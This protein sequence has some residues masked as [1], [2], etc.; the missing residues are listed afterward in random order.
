MNIKDQDEEAELSLLGNN[1]LNQK[2]FDEAIKVFD[3]RV[4]KYPKSAQAHI[5][6]G[7]GHYQN[8][9]AKQAIKSYRTAL[10]LEPRYFEV[11][12]FLGNILMAEGDKL[13]GLE[14][15]KKFFY[16]DPFQADIR[17]MNDAMKAGNFNEAQQFSAHV[18]NRHGSH[19]HALE[20]MAELS[21]RA[22]FH[23]E[24]EK[25]LRHGLVYSPYN[26]IL[27]FK[28]VDTL[29]KLGK[30]EARIKVAKNI[31]KL[32]P[33]VIQ[34]STQLGNALAIAGQYEEALVVY[35]HGLTVDDKCANT[36]YQYG[37]TLKTL[38]RR[39]E[40]EKAYR[41]CLKFKRYNGGVYWALANL[42][43][44]KF[45]EKD[46]K[47]MN[48]ILNDNACPPD[49]ASQAGFALAKA[50]EDKEEYDTAFKYYT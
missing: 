27:W 31:F 9:D 40:C 23:E 11:W 10:D 22:G 13:E 26:I 8:S 43:V 12:H 5:D 35:Q 14:C 48:F 47:A 29:E 38:G 1:L 39:E 17:K 19:P 49:Q 41:K 30:H 25:L 37:H 6:L 4:Q 3:K 44:V 42:K 24:A 18:L 36:L 21:N 45:D 16:Y 33:N 46:I 7:V 34:S 50:Y 28:L 20:V 2:N 32:E 15:F